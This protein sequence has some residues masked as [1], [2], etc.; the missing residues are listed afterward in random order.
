MAAAVQAAA[1]S[2]H[3]DLRVNRGKGQAPSMRGVYELG[4]HCNGRASRCQAAGSSQQS[5]TPR[6]WTAFI[7]TTDRPPPPPPSP[8]PL[9]APNTPRQPSETLRA[10]GT[11]PEGSP[12]HPARQSTPPPRGERQEMYSTALAA[13]DKLRVTRHDQ[14]RTNTIRAAKG[15]ESPRRLPCLNGLL[16]R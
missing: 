4:H 1:P 3:P 16:T 13:S 6:G 8:S 10:S 12:W 15:A 7:H 11:W 2:H 5:R 9:P 14:I